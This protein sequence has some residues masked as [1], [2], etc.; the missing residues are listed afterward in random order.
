LQEYVIAEPWP[1]FSLPP[2]PLLSL[3]L[4]PLRY[5]FRQHLL[6][7]VVPLVVAAVV[8]MVLLTVTAVVVVVAVVVLHSLSLLD[9][10][11]S[12]LEL[13]MIAVKVVA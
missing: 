5:Y 11:L 12:R 4:L 8:L 1:P 2:S 9:P 10:L 3:F 7:L 13:P 6:V